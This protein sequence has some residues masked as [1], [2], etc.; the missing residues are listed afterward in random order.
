MAVPCSQ[1]GQR[2]DLQLSCWERHQ[3]RLVFCSGK[4][5]CVSPRVLG[6]F[7]CLH[8]HQ[9]HQPIFE[10]IFGPSSFLIFWPKVFSTFKTSQSRGTEGRSRSELSVLRMFWYWVFYECLWSLLWVFSEC[11]LSV[12]WVCSECVVCNI[13]IWGN[14]CDLITKEWTKIKKVALKADKAEKWAYYIWEG[15]SQCRWKGP[16]WMVLPIPALARFDNRN[17]SL[18]DTI[19]K[20]FCIFRTCV[21]LVPVCVVWLE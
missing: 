19:S 9:E 10:P 1:K 20:L 2:S 11:S 12:F 21:K 14:W 6:V 3:S 17:Q 15:P 13:V 7:K 4:S 5:K 8:V 18:S 16:A